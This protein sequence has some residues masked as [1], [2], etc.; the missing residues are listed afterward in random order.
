MEDI[1]VA[2]DVAGAGRADQDEIDVLSNQRLKKA[3][4]ALREAVGFSSA[5][6]ITLTPCADQ[7]AVA[8]ASP[9]ATLGPVG[10][11]V[12]AAARELHDHGAQTPQ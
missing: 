10:A 1:G 7:I 3:C 8:P 4:Q 9:K 2:N 12:R 6:L 5:K 11:Q